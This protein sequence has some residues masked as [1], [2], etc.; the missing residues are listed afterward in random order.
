MIVTK[1]KCCIASRSFPLKF[2]FDGN[3]YDEL[4]GMLLRS[5]REC[6]KELQ[7]YDEDADCQILHVKVTY[8]F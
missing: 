7:T 6:E 2:H 5:Y 1:E 8:E 4:D 3:E